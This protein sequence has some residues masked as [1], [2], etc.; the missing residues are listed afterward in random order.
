MRREEHTGKECS[1]F[2]SVAMIKHTN[3][4]IL[5][6]KELVLILPGHY[7]PLRDPGKECKTQA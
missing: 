7:P 6:M 3:K 1:S 5:G 4:R 2:L